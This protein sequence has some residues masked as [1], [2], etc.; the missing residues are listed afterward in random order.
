MTTS[1]ASAA[2]NGWLPSA[3]RTVA[4]VTQPGRQM[5]ATYACAGAS[6]E[7][8][9]T[10]PLEDGEEVLFH[11]AVRLRGTGVLPRA[12]VLRLTRPRLAVLAHHAFGPDRVWELP[13]GS[14]LGIQVRN[15]AL[16][17]SWSS[18]A[19]P[20]VLRLTGWSGRAA[21]PDTPQRD[22]HAVSDVLHSWS[23]T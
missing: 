5:R 8:A 7:L 13:R 21:A 9:R 3:G 11:G 15:G 16:E 19:G 20:S 23:G 12:A 18:D 1:P 6:A 17:L 2:R 14:I 10:L 4:G 22:I